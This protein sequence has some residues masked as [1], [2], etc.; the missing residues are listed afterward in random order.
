[1]EHSDSAATVKK[2]T[3]SEGESKGEPK[4]VVVGGGRAGQAVD[5][6]EHGSDEDDGSSYDVFQ[7]G[8]TPSDVKASRL[9]GD[10]DEDGSEGADVVDDAP[11]TDPVQ[12][13]LPLYLRSDVSI[14]HLK[15]S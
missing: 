12:Y 6:E 7:G 3:K 15:E 2:E 14:K 5:Q 10:G 8:R 4:S 11:P 9:S 1:M 13:Q